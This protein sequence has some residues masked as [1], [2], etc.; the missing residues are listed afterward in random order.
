MKRFLVA[1]AVFCIPGCGTMTDPNRLYVTRIDPALKPVV[2]QWETDCKQ[3]LEQS[4]CNTY[5]IES[6]TR[7]K[8]ISGDKDILGQCSIYY[9]GFEEV[10]YIVLRDDIP[11]NG[12]YMRAVFLHEM[13]HCRLGFETHSQEGLMAAELIYSEKT[14]AAKWAELLEEAYELVK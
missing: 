1:L 11:L 4:R 9:R 13:L 3:H 2:A 5:G 12:Y 8:E 6:I 7:V 10:R 14:L